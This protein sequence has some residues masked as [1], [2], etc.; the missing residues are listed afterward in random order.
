MTILKIDVDVMMSNELFDKYIR[1]RIAII[2][3]LGYIFK[4]IR[5][6]RT[7]K[8]Y[9]FWIEIEEDLSDNEVCELQFLFFQFSL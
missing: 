5:W 7:S 3:E 2:E 8:G 6:S 1:T 4:G 9:H